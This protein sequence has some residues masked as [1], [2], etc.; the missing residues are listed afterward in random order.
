MGERILVTGAA[1]MLGSHIVDRLAAEGHRVIAVDRRP[2]DPGY[3]YRSDARVEPVVGDVTDVGALSELIHRADAV[4]H[5]AAIL[6]HA[7]GDSPAPL[8]AV[9]VAATHAIFEECARRSV[10]VVYA[11]SGSVYGASR[12]AVNG[13]PPAP[14]VEAD[15]PGDL[16]FYGLSKHVNELY[17]D[18]FAR[19]QGLRAVGLRLGTLFGARLRMGLTSRFLLSVLADAEEGRIPE[20][21]EDPDHGREWV[22]VAD[23]AECFVRA[24]RLE[25]PAG[26]IN[27][28]T[29]HPQRLEDVLMTL[30]RLAGAPE[31]IRWSTGSP[32]GGFSAARSYDPALARRVLG[33]APDPDPTAGLRSFLAW[34]RSGAA[35]RKGA[36][37]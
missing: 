13:R 31:E 23:A 34:H 21:S 11:S 29:G 14:F 25:G 9:N 19:E 24:L 28:G 7:D 20:V 16:G 37:S 10:R 33:F 1:G 32:R 3:S 4:V 22:H 6:A 12:P 5:V 15:A 8:M 17:A 27:V 18:V 35:D 2:P 36:R 26:A 30:L